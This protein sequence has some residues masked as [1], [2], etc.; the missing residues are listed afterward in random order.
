MADTSKRI[1]LVTGGNKGLGLETCRRLGEARLT[2]LLGA[3]KREAGETP[4]SR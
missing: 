4:Q 2:V 1:A 3:R